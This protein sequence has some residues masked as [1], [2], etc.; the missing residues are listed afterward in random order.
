MYLHFWFVGK[1]AFYLIGFGSLYP[2]YRVGRAY[3]GNGAFIAVQT[4][5]VNDLQVH[6]AISERSTPFD[7]FGTTNTQIDIYMIFKIR[8]FNKTAFNG[9]CWAKLI[10]SRGCSGIGIRFQITATKVAIAA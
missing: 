5:V 8:F 7:T 10:F 6:R 2:F 1:I 3:P 9:P 4:N